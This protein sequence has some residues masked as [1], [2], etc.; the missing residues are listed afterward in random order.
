MNENTTCDL[1]R[2]ES[3][4]P[5]DSMVMLVGFYIRNSATLKFE[6]CETLVNYEET[7]TKED[8]CQMAQENLHEYIETLV[9]AVES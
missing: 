7:H 6:Y 9:S 1:H 2:Y 4:G 8:I 3:Y 5:T